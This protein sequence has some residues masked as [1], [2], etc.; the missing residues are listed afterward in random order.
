MQC[1]ILHGA[2]GNKNA[3]WFPWLKTEL[4]KQGHEVFLDQYP[5]DSW[6]DIE[7]SG[8]ENTNTVQNLQ[9][10]T[11]FFEQNVLPKLDPT[12]ELVFFGHSLSPVFILHLIT[13]H[14]LRTKG[15][16]AVSPF[17]E[18]LENEATWQFDVVN[19]TFYKTDFDW[20]MLKTLSPFSVVIYGEKDPYV[21]PRFPLKFAKIL[22]S[23]IICVKN[24][25]HLGG[26]L[27]EFPLLLELFKKISK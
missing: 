18:A 15:V 27:T 14:H 24:G 21:P 11:S 16:I 10:W 2:F 6:D 4:Q 22:G 25:G 26:E 9:S 12:Q 17:M 1:V 19:H 3:N 7:K 5:V 20:N 23:E 8:K 13:K